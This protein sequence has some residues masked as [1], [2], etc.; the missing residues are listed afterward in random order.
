MRELALNLMDLAQNSIAAGASFISVKLEEDRA[1]DLLVF[2]ITD[3]GGGMTKEQAALAASPFY[4]TRTTRSIGLGLPLLKAEAERTGG[5]LI[6]RSSPGKGTEVA[7]LFHP[8]HI[9]MVPL[10][11]LEGTVRLLQTCNPQIKFSFSRECRE[12]QSTITRKGKTK[13]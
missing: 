7:A 8:S 1:R 9:D 2:R 12:T 11:D 10:G 13:A 5:E 4:T 3:N 6:L